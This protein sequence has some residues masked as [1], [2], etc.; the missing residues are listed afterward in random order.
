MAVNSVLC[1]YLCSTKAWYFQR[2]A[3]FWCGTMFP[4]GTFELV[5][6]QNS[7]R[8]EKVPQKH[9]SSVLSLRF[10]IF[11]AFEGSE[12]VLPAVFPVRSAL[13]NEIELPYKPA[14]AAVDPFPNTGYRPDR[15]CAAYRQV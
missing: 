13:E 4:R 6:Y 11:E 14:L 3:A 15:R 9:K 5:K 1:A 10:L 12:P 8:I 7:T 2:F